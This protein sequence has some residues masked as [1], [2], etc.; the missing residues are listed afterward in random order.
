VKT[1]GATKLH[2]GAFCSDAGYRACEYTIGFSGVLH[3]DFKHCRY[4]LAWGW[5]LTEA[6]GNQL[7][8][9]TWPRQLLE[10]KEEEWAQSR[11]D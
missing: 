5:N 9:I 1:S 4:L 10:A 3:P 11:L 7:C 2:H 6:G 8:Q